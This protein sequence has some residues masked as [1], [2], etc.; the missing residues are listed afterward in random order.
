MNFFDEFYRYIYSLT[1]FSTNFFNEFFVTILFWRI[2]CD[3]AF[4]RIFCDDSNLFDKFFCDEFFNKFFVTNCF[5]E[6][7]ETK[8]LWR[9]FST[10]LNK[11]TFNHCELGVPPILFYQNISFVMFFYEFLIQIKKHNTHNCIFLQK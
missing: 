10:N 1:I 11:K 9:I 3:E 8:F 2:L 6:F 7:L 5:D 4:W